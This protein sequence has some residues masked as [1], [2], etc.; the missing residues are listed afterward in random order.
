MAREGDHIDQL[1]DEYLSSNLDRREFFKRAG[2]LGLSL[3]FAGTLLAGL[4]R[5]SVAQA[6]TLQRAAVVGGTLREGYDRD[7]SRMDPVNTTWW[8]PGLYPATHEALIATSPK[9]QFQPMLVKSWTVS[10]NGL[11]WTFTLRKGL[12]FQSGAPVTAVAVATAMKAFAN[13]KLAVNA[14]FW[15]PVK[16]IAAVGSDKVKVT[17]SHPYA[18]FPFVLN[19]GYSAIFNAATR[20]KLGDKYGVTATDGTGPF[21]L[22]ELVPGSHAAVTRWDGYPGPGSPFVKNKGKAYLDG[23]RWEVLLEPAK[24]ANELEA[25]NVDALRNPAP[26]DVPRLKRNKNISVIE[27]REQSLYVLGLNF[28]E[29][30]LGFDD[31]RVRQAISYAID[32]NAIVKTVFFGKATPAYTLVPP[33]DP[34]YVK[35]VEKYGAFNKAKANRLL[36]AAGWKRS[37]NGV[38]SKDGQKLSFKI[39]VENDKFEQLIAQAVQQMLRAVG[40]DMQFTVLGSDFFAKF[41]AKGGPIGYMFKNLWTNVMDASILFAGSA[42]AVPACCNAS[43]ASIPTLDKAFDDWQKAANLQQLK[44]A[45]ARAQLIAAQQL[46]FISIVTP[47]VIWAHS[48]KV[49]GWV[50]NESNLYPYYNDVWLKQ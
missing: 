33:S 7:V 44:R 26:Q 22:N 12:K 38:R 5:G 36:D 41:A 28:K 34:F 50:P 10:K 45:S 8:D 25:G 2:A 21:Q 46:P 16:R 32:R 13:P 11:E 49:V 42:F 35:A 14:G 18:D 1:V 3:G 6:A 29:T 39:I 48:K 17:L 15:K 23:I 31:V 4:N 43:N 19:N 40:V 27:L 30:K 47:Y 24:R 9:G 20:N 37:G